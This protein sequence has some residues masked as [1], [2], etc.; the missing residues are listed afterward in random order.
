[1]SATETELVLS[2]VRVAINAWQT[3]FAAVAAMPLL[4]VAIV[5]VTG[6]LDIVAGL[7]LL[8]TMAEI[9]V[10]QSISDMAAPLFMVGLLLMALRT[11]GGAALGVAISRFVVLGERNWPRIVFARPTVRYLAW[12]IALF[13]SPI[14]LFLPLGFIAAS[15]A[16]VFVAVRTSLFFPAIAVDA[17][18]AS[19]STSWHQSRR[20]F[21]RI[22]WSGILALLPMITIYLMLLVVGFTTLTGTGSEEDFLSAALWISL[23]LGSVLEVTATT[24][25]AAVSAW[26]YRSLPIPPEAGRQALA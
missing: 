19:L 13:L 9:V 5:V 10:S 26:I 24:L 15:I 14:V 6:L 8:Q 3:A 21:W 23:L 4:F 1:L 18:H 25:A 20:N 17:P 12:L 7:M 11:Y 16:Y 2:P 22:S